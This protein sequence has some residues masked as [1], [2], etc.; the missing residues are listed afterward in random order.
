MA[1][2]LTRKEGPKEWR[3]SDWKIMDWVPMRN[4][5]RQP[6]PPR[7]QPNPPQPQRNGREPPE[8]PINGTSLAQANPRPARKKTPNPGPR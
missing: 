2:K 4:Q 7:I 8:K 1:K 6:E 3:F 5:I